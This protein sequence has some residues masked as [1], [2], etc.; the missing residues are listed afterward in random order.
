[1]HCI[2]VMYEFYSLS[3]TGSLHEG[4]LPIWNRHYRINWPNSENISF[5][6]PSF[7]PVKWLVLS[8]WWEKKAKAPS[9]N[10]RLDLATYSCHE[11]WCR[12]AAW[13]VITLKWYWVM[14][15]ECLTR[16]QLS[17]ALAKKARIV[18]A[19]Y[20]IFLTANVP[21]TMFT[22]TIIADNTTLKFNVK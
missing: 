1:M 9:S 14:P 19:S 20:A 4:D 2:R 3:S 16:C 13:A 11:I 21:L 6:R 7:S 8:I 22:W 10:I 12:M 17:G 18:I 5:L 15:L